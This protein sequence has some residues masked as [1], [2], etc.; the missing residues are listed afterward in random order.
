M[1]RE[2]DCDE[3]IETP[4]PKDVDAAEGP[5]SMNA[6]E[7]QDFNREL[8]QRTGQCSLRTDHEGLP[9]EMGINVDDSLRLTKFIQQYTT[10]SKHNSLAQ[11]IFTTP[12]ICLYLEGHFTP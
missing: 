7:K 2:L 3:V 9:R 10:N 6:R 5:I 1:L 12:N 11:T 4:I 8:R